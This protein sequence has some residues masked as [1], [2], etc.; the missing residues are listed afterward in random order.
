[1][2]KVESTEKKELNHKSVH[3]LIFAVLGFL[4]PFLVMAFMRIKKLRAEHHSLNLV[5]FAKD[6]DQYIAA[7]SWFLVVWTSLYIAMACGLITFFMAGWFGFPFVLALITAL[8]FA[9]F[10]TAF[11]VVFAF[12]KEISFKITFLISSLVAIVAVFAIFIFLLL[13]GLPAI[14]EIGF[15]R[16]IFGRTWHH[17]PNNAYVSVYNV[18]PMITGTFV[19]ATGA[20]IIG[21]GLGVLTAVCIVWFCPK[22]LK[23]FVT[24]AITLL[25]GIPSVIFGFFGMQVIL[26][27]LANISPNDNGSG[28]L[29]VAIVLGMMILPTVVA[30]SKNSIE[31]V[32]ES[33]FEAG[34]AL[35]ARKERAVFTTVLPSAKSGIFSSLILG[36]GRAVGETM[37]VIMVAG[38]VPSMPG[39]LFQPFRTLTVNIVFEMAYA[40]PGSLHQGALIGTGVIL[41]LFV[42]TINIIFNLVKRRGESVKTPVVF[43]AIKRTISKPFVMLAQKFSKPQPVQQAACEPF[44]FEKAVSRSVPTKMIQVMPSVLKWLSFVTLAL[45]LF[46][47]G[48]VIFY[49]LFN[50]LPHINWGLL[51][52]EFAGWGANAPRTLAP[53]IV[54]TL[55]FV[56]LTSII[57]F[58]I[59]ILAAIFLQEYTKKG[60]KVAK[61]IELAVETLAGIPSIVYGLFGMIFFVTILGLGLSITSGSI[62][63]ALMVLPT[64]I[65]TTQEGLKSVPDTYR[66]GAYALGSGKF[67]T[68]FKVV[69]PSAL[70]SIITMIILGIGRMVAESASLMFT[71]GSSL[72]P[73]PD[74][75]GSSGTTLAVAFYALT[76]DI[77]FINEA[78]AA[79]SILILLVLSLNIGATLA[80]KFVGKKLK[81]G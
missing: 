15:F 45:S 72:G 13:E 79:A 73:M 67:R 41:L 71:M 75:Y 6:S 1:M 61:V 28:P 22:K 48:S 31:A 53:A 62:V 40:E 14:A 68:I 38:N 81:G 10:I 16:F 59:G 11:T 52:G 8:I 2:E 66:E 3:I 27:I 55:M 35:G 78:F 33:Y 77:R 64:T 19:A 57:A 5:G 37:A 56:L 30:I 36:I 74:G 76:R 80:A 42:L 4:P 29:A 49:V 12:D 32:S 69:I 7:A 21:G 44:V 25:A 65:R 24:Q 23:P 46:F 70:P 51:T 18:F 43:P 47:L 63:V 60:S 39:G 34:V 20:L 54:T 26:P 50:G 9:T 17:D 58:P